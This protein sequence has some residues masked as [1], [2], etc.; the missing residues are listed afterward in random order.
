[1]AKVEIVPATLADIESIMVTLY[2]KVTAVPT[3]VMAFAGRTDDGKV[4]GVGGV[5]FYPTGARVAFC[6]VGDEGR[7]YKIALHK[8]ALMTI[9][10]ATRMRVKRLIIT[11][12]T[13]HPKTPKWAL[14]LGFTELE[15]EGKTFYVRDL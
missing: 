11:V 12:D 2:G 14:R 1:M 15:A 4:L 5:A 6:D 9:A 3:R 8:A 7:S 13:M 10:A